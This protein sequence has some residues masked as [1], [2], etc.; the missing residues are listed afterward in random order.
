[1]VDPLL[2][3]CTTLGPT[4]GR[5]RT[6]A[7]ILVRYGRRHRPET[8]RGYGPWSFVRKT[9]AGLFGVWRVCVCD[10]GDSYALELGL[11]RERRIHS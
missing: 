3:L 10:A 4:E 1:M 11:P 2:G 9:L 7:A 5:L 6:T 8:F